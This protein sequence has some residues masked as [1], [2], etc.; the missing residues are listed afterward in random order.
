MFEARH[1]LLFCWFILVVS[2]VPLNKHPLESLGFVSFFFFS[3]GG[4]YQFL[5]MNSF[6]ARGKMQRCRDVFGS[7]SLWPGILSRVTVSAIT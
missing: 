1:L 4:D 3:P 6:S 2:V 5:L 7:E